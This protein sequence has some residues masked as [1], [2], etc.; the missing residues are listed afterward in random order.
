MTWVAVVS[1]PFNDC[2]L[3]WSVNQTVMRGEHQLWRQVDLGSSFSSTALCYWKL[4]KGKN[5]SLHSLDFF[6]CKMEM[7]GIQQ[8]VVVRINEILPVAAHNMWQLCNKWSLLIVWLLIWVLLVVPSCYNYSGY[9][10]PKSNDPVFCF[11]VLSIPDFLQMFH[12]IISP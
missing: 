1:L 9:A 12:T 7:M 3:T 4:S 11:S 2:F 8:R 5:L 6:I 10:L